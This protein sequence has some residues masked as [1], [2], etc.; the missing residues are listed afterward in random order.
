MHHL[1]NKRYGAKP[2]IMQIHHEKMIYYTYMQIEAPN[3]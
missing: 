1:S 3:L 2:Y